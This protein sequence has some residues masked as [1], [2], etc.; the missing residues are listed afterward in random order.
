MLGKAGKRVL[1]EG[2]TAPMWAATR[3]QAAGVEVVRD[4]DPVALPKACKND[5]EL[6]GI[7]AAHRRDGAAVSRFLGWLSH[8]SRGGTLREIEVSDRLQALRQETGALRD[9]SFDTIS[10]AGPNGAI[11]HYHATPASERRP[12]RAASTWSIRA[13]STATVR[14]TSRARW[15]SARRPPRCAIASPVS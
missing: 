13:A 5:V 2:A 8:R 6:A 9:L 15:R 4:A 1:L 11:V 3:L 14:P 12:R 10:G 7:R